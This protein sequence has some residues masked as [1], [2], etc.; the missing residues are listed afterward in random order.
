MSWLRAQWSRLAAGI[1]I[2]AVAVVAGVISYQHVEDLSLSLHATI[3]A[4]RL[5]PIGID[6][7]VVIGSVI[8]LQAGD[9]DRWLGWL[10]VGPGLAISLFA[11]VESGAQYGWLSAVWAGI[12]AV[13]FFLA[14]FLLER[15]L[16]AQARRTAPVPV[17][18]PEVTET[19]T[20]IPHQRAPRHALSTTAETLFAAE[21]KRGE[22]PGIRAIKTRARC[23]TPRA[24]EIR[25]QLARTLQAA[26]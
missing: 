1:A 18:V 15:W 23:G 3:M 11:N 5:M 24:Q 7:L 12:P 10:G 2:L 17:I 8:L 14:T 16:K 13:S 26:V 20:G 25:A 22:L 9:A 19:V 21:I 6:G 4:A